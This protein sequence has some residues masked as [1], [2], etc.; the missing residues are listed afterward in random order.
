VQI[1]GTTFSLAPL[2]TLPGKAERIR[3]VRKWT[4]P[5]AGRLRRLVSRAEE[6]GVAEFS[7]D[8]LVI[9]P[10]GRSDSYWLEFEQTG[11][12]VGRVGLDKN[13]GYRLLWLLDGR[14]FEV[15]T[16]HKCARILVCADG[17]FVSESL[18]TET[19]RFLWFFRVPIAWDIRVGDRIV[20][21]V[22]DS[23]PG[24]TMQLLRPDGA[25]AELAT[26]EAAKPTSKEYEQRFT[27]WLFHRKRPTL[28]ER[29]FL[30]RDNELPEPRD[31][32]ERVALTAF[33]LQHRQAYW[34]DD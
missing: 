10:E 33:A 28:N 29:W 31:I 1:A 13:A 24:R 22:R 2:D 4:L 11:V 23:V 12:R 32:H 27:N 26:G 19:R 30:P 25:T 7:E 5:S 14:T 16:E 34:Q 6:V 17:E 9:E 20:Y 18:L 15:A 8:Q 21:T 3:R